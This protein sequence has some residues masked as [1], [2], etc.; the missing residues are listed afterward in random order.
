V[1]FD[2]CF[3]QVGL[4]LVVGLLAVEKLVD[5]AKRMPVGLVDVIVKKLHVLKNIEVGL[6]AVEQLIDW[7]K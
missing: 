1:L 5:W 7:L 2:D 3:V 6:L 4:G